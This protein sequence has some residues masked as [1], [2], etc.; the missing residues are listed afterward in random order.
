MLV[1]IAHCR[2]EE[3]QIR[4]LAAW[5]AELGPY[6][7]RHRLLVGR[8]EGAEPNLFANSGF[9][10]V[11]EITITGDVWQSWPTSCCN[12]FRQIGKHIEF[13]AREPWLWLE[14]DAIPLTP[15]WLDKIEAE[16]KTA[17]KPFMGDKVEVADVPLHMSGIGVYPGVLSNHAGLAYLAHDTAWDVFAAS[18]IVPQAHWTTLIEHS[19]K[20]DSVTKEN[21]RVTF[22]S[23][24]MVDN[25]VS[26][27]AVIYH[28]SKDGSLI[29]RLREREN[30]NAQNLLSALVRDRTEQIAAAPEAGMVC[31]IF[32]KS[33]PADYEWLSY[34]LRSIDK[35]C[36]RFRQVVIIAPDDKCPVPSYPH[37]LIVSPEPPG[38]DGYLWQTAVKATAHLYTDA[39]HILH[40]DS[41][42]I[43]TTPVT[44]DTFF[45]DGKPYWL[46]S[47]YSTIE[48]PWKPITEKFI[49][50]PVENELMRRMPLFIPTF[51]HAELT[52]FC[53]A[54]HGCSVVE[55]VMKQPYREWSEFNALGVIAWEQFHD[56]FTWINCHE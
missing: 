34:C 32:I 52:R 23:Q 55:Y 24:Q 25:E 18:Q 15:D 4:A 45:I 35:F 47:P 12:A 10:Q 41:D 1:T 36:S 40:I 48:A 31:D 27:D 22:A 50:H 53:L 16:Y 28:A 20:R 6:D 5:M 43:F 7:A 29:D 3:A 26:K 51:V 17:G 42:C 37:R 8:D 21:L 44:P 56:R 46:Y 33:Y 14:F 11:E 49:G 9:E 13:G 38:L 39:T 19:W 2:K 54:K 30:N